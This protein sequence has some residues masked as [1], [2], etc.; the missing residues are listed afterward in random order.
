MTEAS[1]GTPSEVELRTVPNVRDHADASTFVKDYLA[2]VD[3]SDDISQELVE[4]Q[5]ADVRQTAMQRGLRP[6]GEPSLIEQ[7]V[8]NKHNVRL[9]YSVDV[10]V[11]TIENETEQG[12][13]EAVATEQTA[14]GEDIE[15]GAGA[16]TADGANVD[17]SAPVPPATGAPTPTN[18]GIDP[19]AAAKVAKTTTASTSKATA[20]AKQSPA[21]TE[22]SGDA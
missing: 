20:S 21:T 7:T 4:R 14:T 5:Y 6:T 1:E 18:E 16:S 13:K 11:A 15:Q 2:W 3:D 9:V 10:V 8:I 19:A 12:T 17:T 22:K